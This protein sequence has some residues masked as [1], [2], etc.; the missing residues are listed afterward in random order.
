MQDRIIKTI[1]SSP[2]IT[3]E[4]LA[5]TCGISRG[6]VRYH[7]DQLKKEGRLQRIGKKG[8]YWKIRNRQ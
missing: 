6:G 8:G 4:K 7:L 3:I 2:D 5:Q 1:K